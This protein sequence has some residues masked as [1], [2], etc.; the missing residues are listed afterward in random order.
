MPEPR[1]GNPLIETSAGL[2]VLVHRVLTFATR[3]IPVGLA[4]SMEADT[5][6]TSIEKS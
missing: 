5:D 6:G 2:A 3:E 4:L 1:G